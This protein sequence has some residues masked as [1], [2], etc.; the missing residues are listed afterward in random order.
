[1]PSVQVTVTQDDIDQGVRA[2]P[3]QCPVARAIKRVLQ[4]VV[5]VGTNDVVLVSVLGDVRTDRVL[6]PQSVINWIH[7]YDL[8]HTTMYTPLMYTPFSF[9]LLDV[10]KGYI[11]QVSHPEPGI[12]I[13]TVL[14]CPLPEMS[15][16][17][18]VLQVGM[19]RDNEDGWL[20]IDAI[21][22]DCGVVWGY[23]CIDKHGGDHYLEAHKMGEGWHS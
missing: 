15:Q 16:G 6:L 20:M 7:D 18:K 22:R 21:D 3:A 13:T 12:K 1:M 11:R 2:N 14:P 8:G 23:H 10:P 17:R 5:A 9:T 19:W 4:A